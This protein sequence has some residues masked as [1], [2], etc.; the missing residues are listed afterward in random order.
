MEPLP[1][2]AN[3]APAVPLDVKR[4]LCTVAYP[5]IARSPSLSDTQIARRLARVAPSPEAV[6]AL[7]EWADWAER[8]GG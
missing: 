5:L 8:Y 4:W 7:E 2:L 1:G 6:R 3:P